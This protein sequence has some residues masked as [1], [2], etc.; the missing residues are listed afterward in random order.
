MS[1]HHD[2]AWLSALRWG[3]LTAA[4]QL[5]QPRTLIQIV[6]LWCHQNAPCG[7][8]AEG[9]WVNHPGGVPAC[10][11]ALTPCWLL[12]TL[13]TRT[14]QTA[15]M[16]GH[17]SNLTFFLSGYRFSLLKTSPN[18]YFNYLYLLKILSIFWMN[19]FFILCLYRVNFFQSVSKDKS[20][21]RLSFPKVRLKK[22]AVSLW[23]WYLHEICSSLH[24][25][26]YWKCRR[27]LVQQLGA[28]G[29]QN[30]KEY[31]TNYIS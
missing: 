2:V 30:P 18:S 7:C 8:G 21:P 5:E 20:T 10:P 4:S 15:T 28:G 12:P 19:G 23:H 9:V 22:R 3:C 29:K 25:F 14:S 26:W 27:R 11:A 31:P 1:H 6:R 17:I 24:P 16:V 13:S